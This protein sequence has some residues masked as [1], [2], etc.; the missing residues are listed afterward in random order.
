MQSIVF[1]ISHFPSHLNASFKLAGA[2]KLKGYHI[3]YYNFP[4]IKKL[5]TSQGYQFISF[6]SE[7]YKYD[8]P[9]NNNI[10]TSSIQKYK[11]KKY[12]TKEFLKGNFYDEMISKISPCL[13]I[14]DLSLIY[15]SVFLLKKNFP[16][17]IA[18]SKV[19]LNRTK[20]APPFTS[21]YIPYS[22]NLG[23][24]IYINILWEIQILQNI[25]KNIILNFTLDKVS[26]LSKNILEVS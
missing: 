9:V 11:N 24:K 16:F 5:I 21:N 15:Y 17:I 1:H 14:V 20:I 12:Y 3:Y 23:A 18:C 4:H 2:L 26:H 8:F 19:C 6:P 7:H 25:L 13:I 10:L 22:K